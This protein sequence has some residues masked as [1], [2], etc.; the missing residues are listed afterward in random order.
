MTLDS[1]TR[2]ADAPAA[3]AADSS[4]AAQ[5][6]KPTT[7]RRKSRRGWSM[8][9]LRKVWLPLLIIIV[10]AIVGYSM[11]VARVWRTPLGF[12]FID[13]GHAEALVDH[14]HLAA[15]HQLAVDQDLE[16]LAD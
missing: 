10:V 15:S 9:L 4:P 1:E 5:D 16:R 2:G 6:G 12:L 11:P 7:R 13:G 14:H 8:R 3:Q